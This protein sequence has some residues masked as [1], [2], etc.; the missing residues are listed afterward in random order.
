MMT[1]LI[2]SMTFGVLSANST[3]D[4]ALNASSSKSLEFGAS[5]DD[6]TNVTAD[7]AD[8]APSES[9]SGS[10]ETDCNLFCSK[11]SNCVF[12]GHSKIFWSLEVELTNFKTFLAHFS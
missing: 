9:S 2:I 11:Y 8:V 1:L 12:T 7:G 5:K 4:V 6:V 10:R 3:Q